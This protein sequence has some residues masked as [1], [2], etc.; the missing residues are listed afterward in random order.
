MSFGGG[1]GEAEAEC[2]IQFIVVV[3]E[4]QICK[5][6]YLPHLMYNAKAKLANQ[7]FLIQQRPEQA[8]VCGMCGL[9]RVRGPS[10]G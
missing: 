8:Q 7:S 3:C 2:K 10:W 5:L 1:G 9:C 4:D 6:I